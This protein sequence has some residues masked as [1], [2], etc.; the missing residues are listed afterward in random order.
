M[1]NKD[2]ENLEDIYDNM[3]Q[4]EKG[5]YIGGYDPLINFSKKCIDIGKKYNGL[6]IPAFVLSQIFKRIADDQY[7]RAVTLIESQEIYDLLDTPLRNLF[8][9]LKT[10]TDYQNSLISVI[11]NFEELFNE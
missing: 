11:N 2:I 9:D 10:D 5:G 7:E 3:T 4:N 8:N 1:I 6:N